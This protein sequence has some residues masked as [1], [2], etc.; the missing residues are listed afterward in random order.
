MGGGCLEKEVAVL[1]NEYFGPDTVYTEAMN[2]WPTYR[3]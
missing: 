2:I 1:I 3:A